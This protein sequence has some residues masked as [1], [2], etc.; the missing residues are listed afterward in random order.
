M[1]Q[2]S[3]RLLFLCGCA[4]I[5][6]LRLAGIAASQYSRVSRF[7]NQAAYNEYYYYVVD[8]GVHWCGELCDASASHAG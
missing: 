3:E 4:V 7:P 5:L 2:V 6:I 1:P 8:F